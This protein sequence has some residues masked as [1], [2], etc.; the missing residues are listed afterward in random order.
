MP[1]CSIRIYTNITIEIFEKVNITPPPPSPAATKSVMI[2]TLPP[3][4]GLQNNQDLQY[5]ED[6]KLKSKESS[7]LYYTFHKQMGIGY[8][9][10][11]GKQTNQQIC[12]KQY[13]PS[14]SKE[15]IK[16]SWFS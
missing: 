3:I 14:C 5:S 10:N 8:Q 16:N 2:S 15:G 13:A 11:Q 9:G 7:D 6:T 12:T 1:F 4:P